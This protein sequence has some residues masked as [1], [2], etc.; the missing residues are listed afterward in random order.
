MKKLLIGFLAVIIFVVIGVFAV[1][2]YIT[3][4][5]DNM[6]KLSESADA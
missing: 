3:Q 1:G 6:V 2:G 5:Y 4:S